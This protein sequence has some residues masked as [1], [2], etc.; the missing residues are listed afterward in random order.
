MRHQGGRW[1]G[2]QVLASAWFAHE[3]LLRHDAACCTIDVAGADREVGHGGTW[4]ADYSTVVAICN[5]GVLKFV[6]R[7]TSCP[8]LCF[9]CAVA[10][11]AGIRSTAGQHCRSGHRHGTASTR[12]RPVIGGASLEPG[13]AGVALEPYV[14]LGKGGIGEVGR[15]PWHSATDVT[16]SGGAR[17]WGAAAGAPLRKG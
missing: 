4:Q 1:E 7:G 3:S 15:M 6:T 16:S 5:A 13:A 14:Q 9:G 8:T 11:L 12:R 2:R 17:A 10:R